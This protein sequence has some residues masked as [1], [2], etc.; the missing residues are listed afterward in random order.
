[1]VETYPCIKCRSPLTLNAG[2]CDQCGHP[3]SGSLWAALRRLEDQLRDLEK[4][5]KSK[6]M[7]EAPT[8]RLKKIPMDKFDELYKKGL[9]DREIAR[10]LGVAFSRIYRMRKKLNLQANAPRG[11]PKYIYERRK[12]QA[13]EKADSKT[14]AEGQTKQT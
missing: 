2:F 13:G 1:M 7:I 4:Q 3:S 12:K 6:K 9:N 14:I 11:F 5:V 8:V 10:E